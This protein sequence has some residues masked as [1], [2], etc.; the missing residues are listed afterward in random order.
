MILKNE[1]ITVIK[2]NWEEKFI[3]IN[4]ISNDFPNLTETAMPI[5]AMKA[6]YYYQ[7]GMKDQ[8]FSLRRKSRRYGLFLV[9]VGSSYFALWCLKKIMYAG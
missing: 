6:R 4:E 8:A 2:S 1:D 7:N 9:S 3:N 5:K